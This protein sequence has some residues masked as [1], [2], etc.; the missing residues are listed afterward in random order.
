[1]DHFPKFYKLFRVALFLSLSSWSTPI[2]AQQQQQFPF[3]NIFGGFPSFFGE[4]LHKTI[5]LCNV[6]SLR[7]Q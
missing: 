1:M 6:H 4:P 2:M 7:H 5:Y 3:G